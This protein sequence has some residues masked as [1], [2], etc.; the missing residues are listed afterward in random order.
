M[1][2]VWDLFLRI[3]HWMVALAFFVAYM[4]EDDPLLLH[5]W[6]GYLVG[7]LVLLRLLWGLIGPRHARFTDFL[8]GPR[9]VLAYLLDLT[10][11]RAKRYLGHS[12]AGGAMA[13]AMWLGLLGT[14]WTGIE[15]YAEEGGEFWEGIHE[16]FASLTLVLLILHIG[17]VTLASLVH[18]ENLVRAMITGKKRAP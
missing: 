6:A 18:R 11:L 16:A 2:P 4:T 15:L 13:L 3:S 1:I 12:P 10:A 7:G 8:C 5:V 9:S 17:G 14:V